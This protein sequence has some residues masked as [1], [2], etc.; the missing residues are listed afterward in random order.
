MTESNVQGIADGDDQ[1][2]DR[3]WLVEQADRYVLHLTLIHGGKRVQGSMMVNGFML[4]RMLM[5]IR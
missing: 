2:C 3:M 5:V 4:L 1:Q